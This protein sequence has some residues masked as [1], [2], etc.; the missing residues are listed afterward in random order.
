M[1]EFYKD[2][3]LEVTLRFHIKVTA[4]DSEAVYGVAL[5]A[6]DDT[7]VRNVDTAD[8][9]EGLHTSIYEGD[10]EIASSKFV[11]SELKQRDT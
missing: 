8:D 6:L 11:V 7:I 1:S 3:D 5:D 2:I 9:N 4:E 10:W